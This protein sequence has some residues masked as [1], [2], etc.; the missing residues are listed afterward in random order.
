MASNPKERLTGLFQS[1]GGANAQGN[2]ALRYVAPREPSRQTQQQ[3]ATPAAA[4]AAAPTAASAIVY[5]TSVALFKYDTSARKY[6]QMSDAAAPS[7]VTIGCVIVGSGTAY[8][9]LFYTASKQHVCAV[10]VKFATLKPTLQAKHYVNLYDDKGVNW[11]VKFT[12][13]DHVREFM[14][15]VFLV[16]I[17]EEIWGDEKTRTK[18]APNTLISDDLNFSK[19]D[20]Y[21]VRNGDTVAVS[22]NCWRVVGNATC[23]PQDVVTKYPAFEQASASEL[24]KFRLGG[25]S[26]RIK[27]LEEGVVGMQKGGKRMILAPPGKTNGQDWYLIEVELV[28]TKSGST[29]TRRPTPVPTPAPAPADEGEATAKTPRSRPNSGGKRTPKANLSDELVPYDEAVQDELQLKELKLKQRE[30]E[31]EIQAKA[32]Q[33]AQLN[34]GM[35]NGGMAQQ[36]Q[37]Q[38]Q[39]QAA[40]A[41]AALY[42]QPSFSFSPFGGAGGVFPGANAV[43]APGRPLDSMLMELNAKVDYL[44]RMAPTANSQNSFGAGGMSAGAADVSSVIRGVERLAGENERLLLQINSQNQ[45]YTSYEKRCEELLRQNQKLQEEKRAAQENYQSVASQQVNFHAELA[46]V[47]SA[48]DAAITQTN[49][50]HAE[51]QQLLAAFYQKQQVSSEWRLGY[52]GLS[53]TLMANCVTCL[54]LRTMSNAMHWPLNVTHA[55]DWRRNCRKRPKRGRWWSRNCSLSRSSTLWSPR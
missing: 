38:Q 23:P 39:Q 12:S 51:Y 19:A 42:G 15:N 48:R 7:N 18:A 31:L 21:A 9:L 35:F 40:A 49:R 4:P 3:S 27:A 55:C 2:D 47:A 13:D 14:R 33:Q 34:G 44:I 29:T 17:H 32:L 30:K 20:G 26:E 46:S 43:S 54:Q 5:S 52:C 53:L 16:K 10:P 25:G 28:K 6:V 8:T 24:R 22:F 41:A 11:S 45:Q 37:Q 1:A 50:L 36:Q